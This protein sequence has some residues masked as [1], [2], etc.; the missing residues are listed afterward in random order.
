MRRNY[1]LVIGAALIL[2]TSCGPR[3][4]SCGGKRRCISMEQETKVKKD[5]TKAPYEAINKK[6]SA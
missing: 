3:R 2:L 4:F 6:P 1:L 5:K